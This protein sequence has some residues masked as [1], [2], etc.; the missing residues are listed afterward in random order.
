MQPSDQRDRFP[1]VARL[2]HDLEVRA[3]FDGG[4]GHPPVRRGIIDED[5]AE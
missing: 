1:A 4:P 5:D 2:T 3:G